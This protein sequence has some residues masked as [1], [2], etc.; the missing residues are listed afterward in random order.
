MKHVLIIGSGL[1]AYG[2]LQGL[3]SQDEC[4]SITIFDIGLTKPYYKQ[5]NKVIFN[6]KPYDNCY[7]IYG[8]NDQRWHLKLKSERI[9]SSHGF[10]GF[11]KVYSG[12]VAY[13]KSADLHRWPCASIPSPADYSAL[14]SDLNISF[15]SDPINSVFPLHPVDLSSIGC[16]T[17]SVAGFSRVALSEPFPGKF[18]PFDSSF[19]IQRLIRD[20]RIS[21]QRDIRVFHLD[22]HANLV[23]VYCE[24]SEGL[25]K[26]TFDAVYVGA[27]CINTTALIDKSIYG[28]GKREYK[29]HQVPL[30]LSLCLKLPFAQIFK[31][32]GRPEEVPNHLLDI[33]FCRFFIE[34]KLPGFDSWTHTQVGHLNDHGLRIINDSLGIKLPNRIL[35]YIS[36]LFMFASTAFHSDLGLSATIRSS[37]LSDNKDRPEQ[38]I[39]V[40]EPK[41]RLSQHVRRL[42]NCCLWSQSC[43]LGIFPLAFG[44]IIGDLL[45]GNQL[46]GWHYGGTL[47]MMSDPSS[48]HECL[49]SGEVSGLKNVYVIDSSCFPSIPGST[50]ALLTMANSHRIAKNSIHNL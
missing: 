40:V 50:V 9:C 36:R 18:V 10:G 33:N 31:L 49:P 11:S 15:I 22:A 6:A 5:P 19:E 29:L 17:S 23:D 7:S 24:S 37:V 39:C 4:I 34:Y 2:A 12:S 48:P 26:H 44:R 35:K 41:V 30:M 38:E 3:L 20:G 45:R 32:L 16:T 14:I 46:G 28:C 25:I 8:V 13:P 47:P 42:V 1:A 27:G 21:Y 43:F